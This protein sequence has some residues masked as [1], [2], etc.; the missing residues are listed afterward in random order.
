MNKDKFILDACCG[1]RSIW[2]QKEQEN[3]LYIDVRKEE[4][5]FIAQRPNCNINPDVILDFR[6]LPFQD[7]KFKL[8]VWDPP[9]LIQR[10]QTG[11]IIKKYGSLN[12]ISWEDDLKKGFAELWRCLDNYGVLIFK[13][14]NLNIPINKVINLFPHKPLF[15]TTTNKRDNAI[16]RW[17]TYMKIPGG[18]NG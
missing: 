9:H 1:P 6:K 12:P 4:K 3:T 16:T 7:K 5:G 13:F 18:L 2:V 15:G 10:K 17:F 14:C 11:I 8:I